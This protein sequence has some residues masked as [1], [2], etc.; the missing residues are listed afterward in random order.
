MIR[1]L[2]ISVILLASNG[3]AHAQQGKSKMDI[4]RKADLKTVPGP[5]A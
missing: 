1:V 2:T 5:D 4:S 3:V